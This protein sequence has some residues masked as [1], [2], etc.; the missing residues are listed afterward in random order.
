MIA[1]SSDENNTEVLFTTEDARNETLQMAAVHSPEYY[2]PAPGERVRRSHRRERDRSWL[3]WWLLGPA[4]LAV[5]FAAVIGVV[6]ASGGG[7]AREQA[8]PTATPGSSEPRPVISA[9]PATPRRVVPPPQRRR[10]APAL[11]VAPTKK[12][13]K[14]T[15]KPSLSASQKPVKPSPSATP[16]PT[17]TV[18]SPMPGASGITHHTSGKEACDDA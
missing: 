8:R 4:V 9:P 15:P 13:P 2:Q 17:L 11:P 7:A 6:L 3:S 14:T 10:P 12:R 1:R 18:P 5:V 16:K